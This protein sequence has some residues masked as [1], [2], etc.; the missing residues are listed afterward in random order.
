MF[1]VTAELNNLDKIIPSRH[2]TTISQYI[3]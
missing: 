1:L 3:L 2:K